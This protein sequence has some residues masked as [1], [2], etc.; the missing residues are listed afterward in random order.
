MGLKVTFKFRS[1]VANRIA[2]STSNQ[3]GDNKR[4]PTH[5]AT[6]NALQMAISEM[7]GTS[8]SPLSR[9]YPR[10]LLYEVVH[11]DFVLL[12]ADHQYLERAV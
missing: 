7:S 10:P 11:L 1:L 5:P 3:V 2:E 9:P 6:I 12:S 8:V 4:Q